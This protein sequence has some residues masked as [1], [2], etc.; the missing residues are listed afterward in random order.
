MQHKLLSL[1]SWLSHP[2]RIRFI[3][4]A[5]TAVALLIPEASALAENATGGSG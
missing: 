1:W 4:L 2:T 3:L 5:L